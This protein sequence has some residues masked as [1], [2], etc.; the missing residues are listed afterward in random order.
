MA[1]V[2][3]PAN[4]STTVSQGVLPQ[5]EA[6]LGEWYKSNVAHIQLLFDLDKIYLAEA[7]VNQLVAQLTQLEKSAGDES[8]YTRARDELAR[9]HGTFFPGWIGDRL[10]QS[11]P[12]SPGIVRRFC[13]SQRNKSS[14]GQH[15][16]AR[17]QNG[18]FRRFVRPCVVTALVLTPATMHV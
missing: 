14:S 18:R 15:P 17:R 6:S 12:S 7:A 16:F 5:D 11:S 10:V 3:Q 4:V 2:K 13:P 9:V 8:M 1:E